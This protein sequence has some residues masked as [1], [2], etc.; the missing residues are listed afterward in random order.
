MTIDNIVTGVQS[1][2]DGSTQ[3]IIN[4]NR[5][6]DLVFAQGSAPYQELA[7]RA[8]LYSA[9][10]QSAQA[11]SVGL[12]TTYTGLC[13]SN[14]LNSG[15]NLV[16]LGCSFGLTVAPAA[17]A[18]L[19]LISGFS[20]TANVTHTTPVTINNNIIGAGLDSIAKVDS[21]ATISTPV[22]LVPLCS[23]FTAAALPSMTPNWIDLKGQF[24]IP[25]G[26]F[27][28]IGALTAVTGFGGFTWAEVP[29]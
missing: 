18:S 6:G 27:V 17:I 10:N 23:G 9:S 2:S 22:Y 26:G 7:L 21:A 14:P 19:H 13:L 8:F 11:V 28:A 15:Y 16:L 3:K 5:Q 29:A 20:A 1:L 12:A 24:I 25:Q 4:A